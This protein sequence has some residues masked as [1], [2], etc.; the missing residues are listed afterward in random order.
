LAAVVVAAPIH[1]VAI[2]VSATAYFASAATGTAVPLKVFGVIAV[3]ALPPAKMHP[4]MELV[5]DP[6]HVSPP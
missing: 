5:A 1:S 3:L 2:P 4:E 6:V